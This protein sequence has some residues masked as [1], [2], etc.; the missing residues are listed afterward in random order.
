M[1]EYEFKLKRTSYKSADLTYEADGRTLVVYLEMSGTREFDW[2]GC[3]SGFERWSEPTREP[4][5]ATERAQILSRLQSWAS[6]KNLKSDIGPGM[7]EEEYFQLMSKD[8]WTMHTRSDGATE[9]RPPQRSLV[10]RV[11]MFFRVLRNL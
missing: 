3:D 6:K 2:L 10:K 8:G 9:W 11:E 1:A 7:N 4:I 5:D